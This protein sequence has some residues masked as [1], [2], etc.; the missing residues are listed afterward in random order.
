MSNIPEF[1][2]STQEVFDYVVTFLRK[3][4]KPASIYSSN[5]TV[6]LGPSC[7]YRLEVSPGE[8]LCC[9]A[10]CLIPKE[11]YHPGMEGGT[12]VDRG[13]RDEASMLVWEFFQNFDEEVFDLIVELQD[14]HDTD[15]DLLYWE[16]KW[17]DLAHEF[18]LTMP[19]V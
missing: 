14:I 10:G 9:A 11:A 7:R 18:N 4:G 19:K 12:V 2:A 6:H 8:I 15:A 5:S 1:S 13:E 17:Q 16:R 3:Q